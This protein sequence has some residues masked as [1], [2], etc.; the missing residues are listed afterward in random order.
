MNDKGKDSPWLGTIVSP[1]FVGDV[2]TFSQPEKR[3]MVAVLEGAVSDF[4]KY[5]TAP[6]GRGRRLFMEA[7]AWFESA[8]TDRPLDFES[9]CQAV[10]IDPSFIREGL[11]RWCIARR[12]EPRPS[13]AMLHLPVHPVSGRQHSIAATS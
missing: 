7:D 2:A 10:G 9:I 11:R 4:Q 12:L 8:A 6:S 13:R 5:A 1:S 3:L